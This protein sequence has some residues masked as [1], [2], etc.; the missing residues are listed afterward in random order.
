MT[1]QIVKNIVKCIYKFIYDL[2]FFFFV[3]LT[4]DFNRKVSTQNKYYERM[5][6]CDLS[7]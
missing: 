2:F 5:N 4:V 7:R 1:Q 3:D 6:E